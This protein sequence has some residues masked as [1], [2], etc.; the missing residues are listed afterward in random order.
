M[1]VMWYK[2]TKERR[3]ETVPI[4]NDHNTLNY[5]RGV[6]SLVILRLLP[7]GPR[8]FGKGCEDHQRT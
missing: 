4:G 2:I 3:Q 6:L 5:R 1:Q 7:P 8:F